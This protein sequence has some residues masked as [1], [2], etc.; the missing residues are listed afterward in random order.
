MFPCASIMMWTRCRWCSF[1]ASSSQITMCIFIIILMFEL[2][3]LQSWPRKNHILAT[4]GFPWG[5]RELGVCIGV[6]HVA[7]TYVATEILHALGAF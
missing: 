2:F 7:W 3:T 1:C 4:L 5:P 6:S